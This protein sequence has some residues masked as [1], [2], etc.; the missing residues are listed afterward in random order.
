MPFNWNLPLGDHRIA[1]AGA[2]IIVAMD[3]DNWEQVINGP[4]MLQY[5]LPQTAIFT[6]EETP[7]RPRAALV[8]SPDLDLW[9]IRGAYLLS[10]AQMMIRGYLEP[11]N[12]ELGIY[13]NRAMWESAIAL[14][15]LAAARRNPL[16]PNCAFFGH[17]YGSGIAAC[18]AQAYRQ[19]LPLGHRRVCA[20]GMPRTMRVGDPEQ[21]GWPAIARYWNTNDSVLRLCPLSNEAAVGHFLL[22]SGMSANLNTFRHIGVPFHLTPDNPPVQ[23]EIPPLN[24]M[25]LAPDIGGWMANVMAGQTNDHSI[26]VYEHNLDR[27]ITGEEYE[28]AFRGPQADPVPPAQQGEAQAIAP[29]MQPLPP[30]VVADL[31]REAAAQP[32]PPA[33]APQEPTPF[34]VWPVA[35]YQRY[36]TTRRVNRVWTILAAGRPFRIART[37][38][39]ARSIARRGNRIAN[40]IRD[41]GGVD[42]TPAETAVAA[43][44]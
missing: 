28:A 30:A 19:Y 32:A 2:R 24:S 42:L 27:A 36:F 23:E 6:F 43:M 38:R 15:N 44:N 10:H 18:M 39:R 1:L 5:W 20:Y 35:S 34:M 31:V 22:P 25:T 14:M 33:P 37:K 4:G 11:L 16:N 40:A 8:A 12:A 29:A 17:S 21:R 3:A 7:T 26:S 41:A 13:W 9:F